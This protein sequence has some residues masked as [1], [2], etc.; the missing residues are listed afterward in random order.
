[1]IAGLS[2]SDGLALP[3]PSLIQDGR[4]AAPVGVG[5]RLRGS[6]A[7]LSYRRL[8]AVPFSLKAWAMI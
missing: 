4:A 2:P 7:I 5:T 3:A 8:A 6:S 1:V